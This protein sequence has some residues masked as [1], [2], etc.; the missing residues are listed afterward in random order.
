MIDKNQFIDAAWAHLKTLSVCPK[1]GQTA[2]ND[3]I[4][5]SQNGFGEVDCFHCDHPFHAT[6]YRRVVFETFDSGWVKRTYE[7][8]Y[9][10][11]VFQ[12]KLG[13]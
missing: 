9:R 8:L 11:A 10:Y 1:C 6:R 12:M 5:T 4:S 3:I 13:D 2:I 7:A